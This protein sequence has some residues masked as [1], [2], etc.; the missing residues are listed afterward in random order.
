MLDSQTLVAFRHGL[1]I[2]QQVRDFATLSETITRMISIV[3][4]DDIHFAYDAIARVLRAKQEME[5]HEAGNHLPAVSELDRK[6][7]DLYVVLRTAKPRIPEPL[8]APVNAVPAP[9]TPDS[10]LGSTPAPTPSLPFG[11]PLALLNWLK[12]HKTT[13][14]TGTA[15]ASTLGGAFWLYKYL[16][17]EEMPKA[18]EPNSFEKT[19]GSIQKYRAFSQLMK[20]P[21]I[22][23]VQEF[24]IGK[25]AGG[26]TRIVVP[27]KKK[28][29][30]K[31][32]EPPKTSEWET[33]ERSL[34]KDMDGAF[35][36][37]S[38]RPSIDFV[39]PQL[40]VANL[41]DPSSVIGAKPSAIPAPE[42]KEK[43]KS[44]RAENR[45]NRENR[46]KVEKPK[47]ES[48][49]SSVVKVEEPKTSSNEDGG[50]RLI[51]IIKRTKRVKKVVA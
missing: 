38:Q 50:G 18:A 32:E 7:Q 5:L 19:I 46:I 23:D 17:T 6:Y 36:A 25:S 45:E 35:N 14:V 2:L 31:K 20:N 8:V 40:P 42:K 33:E 26:K 21:D 51:P 47:Q 16:T 4:P 11:N 43:K 48:K 49:E 9:Q 22:S 27:N 37:L 30:E 24:L 3:S 29:P 44:E 39:L 28:K 41:I 15:V 12:D 10:D 34:M 1:N 13:L